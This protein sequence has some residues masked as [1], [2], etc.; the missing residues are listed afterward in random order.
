MNGLLRQQFSKHLKRYLDLNIGKS[1]T[2]FKQEQ[3]I[4]FIRQ[5]LALH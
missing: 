5:H 3:L 1:A 4:N 2:H